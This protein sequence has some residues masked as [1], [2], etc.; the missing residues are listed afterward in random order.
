MSRS[1]RVTRL[2]RWST[3]VFLT[4]DELPCLALVLGASVFISRH[5]ADPLPHR[6]ALTGVEDP[7]LAARDQLCHSLCR[8]LDHELTARGEGEEL[9]GLRVAKTRSREHLA[10]LD[11]PEALRGAVEDRLDI[12]TRHGVSAR[13]TRDRL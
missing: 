4:S 11:A 10:A 3:P 1:S 8:G 2:R 12:S 6:P 5:Q 9:P 13:R 7:A